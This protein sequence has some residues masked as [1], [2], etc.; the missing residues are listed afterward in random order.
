MQRCRVPIVHRWVATAVEKAGRNLSDSHNA[1]L[2]E[3]FRLQANRHFILRKGIDARRDVFGW[4]GF[5]P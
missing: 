5:F 2:K 1:S 3:R 4:D